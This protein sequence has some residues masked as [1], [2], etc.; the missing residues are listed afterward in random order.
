M[1]NSYDGFNDNM[2][3]DIWKNVWKVAAPKRYLSFLWLANH[4]RL[5]T[6]LSKSRKGLGSAECILYGNVNEFAILA[7][8]DCPKSMKIWKGIVPSNLMGDFFQQT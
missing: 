6:N 3:G 1:L 5:L 4:D 2:E 8:R 7:L